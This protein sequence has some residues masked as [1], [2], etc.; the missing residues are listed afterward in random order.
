MT[1]SKKL[2]ML[3][4]A[5]AFSFGM[6]AC[7]DDSGDDNTNNENSGNSGDNN[8]NSGD[9]NGNSGNN[10]GSTACTEGQFK[11][12]GDFLVKCTDGNWAMEEMCG[13][14]ECKAEQGACVKNTT[15]VCDPDNYKGE[16]IDKYTLQKCAADGLS[17]ISERCDDGE[18]CS[19]DKNA[20]E[21]DPCAPCAAQGKVCYQ[22]QCVDHIEQGIIGT[23]C[24][25]NSNCQIKISGKEIKDSVNI[26]I[27]SDFKGIVDGV[28]GVLKIDVD[29][30]LAEINRIFNTIKD[31][32][33]IVA[34]NY[35]S[36]DIT[37]CDGLVAPDGMAV[38]CFF[39][40]TITF[41][42]SITDVLDVQLPEFLNSEMFLDVKEK[43]KT[44]SEDPFAQI[45]LKA[46][47]KDVDLNTI[48]SYLDADFIMGKVKPISDLLKEGIKFT[49]PN[50]YCMTADI[51]IKADLSSMMTEIMPGVFSSDGK[52]GLVSKINTVNLGTNHDKAKKAT[53]P[54]GSTLLSYTIDK[55]NGGEI[56]MVGTF[57]VGFD[58][59]AQQ[60]I[61]SADCRQDEGYSCIRVPN[62]APTGDGKPVTD[63]SQVCFNAD[64]IDYFCDMTNMFDE[65]GSE[66]SCSMEDYLVD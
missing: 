39:S 15:P 6:V 4:A 64:M 53:C 9:N 10:G 32:E 55:S 27:P 1:L 7:D 44:T 2:I 66:K 34:P 13:A 56:T 18:R 22:D 20:C 50:G 41:P 26:A 5:L 31:D 43:I 8:G 37:G 17:Y 30:L 35:F 59:C 57:N 23:A 48:L 46:F 33:E 63:Y 19:F 62:H 21:P 54:A 36:Q 16:C 24:K 3:S 58:I 14:G 52:S 40:D 49:A 47:M 61:T 51:E 42:K 65:E 12:Q 25:C 11:C 60:C 45:L 29:A 28:A 38:G